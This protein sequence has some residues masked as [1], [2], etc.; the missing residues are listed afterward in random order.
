[1]G[2]IWPFLAVA[3]GLYGVPGAG[4][5]L[6]IVDGKRGKAALWRVLCLSAPQGVQVAIYA[7]FGGIGGNMKHLPYFGPLKAA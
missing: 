7:A 2:C 6:R 1:M 4:V 5:Y 3:T